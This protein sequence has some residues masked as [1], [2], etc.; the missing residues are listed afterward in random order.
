M[1]ASSWYE[2]I[3]LPELRH[4]LD[5]KAEIQTYLLRLFGIVRDVLSQEIPGGI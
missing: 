2:H 4:V 3:L 1:N 5:T